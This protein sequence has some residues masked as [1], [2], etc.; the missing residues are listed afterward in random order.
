MSFG[1]CFNTGKNI[2]I[3]QPE[4]I[5]FNTTCVQKGG[6][7][8]SNLGSVVFWILNNRTGQGHDSL[9]IELTCQQKFTHQNKILWWNGPN[10]F[11]FV[12]GIN[13]IDLG[14]HQTRWVWTGNFVQLYSFNIIE[15]WPTRF[16]NANMDFPR[17]KLTET[18]YC[19][20]NFLLFVL[21][22]K[23][24]VSRQ[25]GGG[26]GRDK[27][28]FRGYTWVGD[29]IVRSLLDERPTSTLQKIGFNGFTIRRIQVRHLIYNVI[30]FF[31][32]KN[33]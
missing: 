19:R 22:N 21:Q 8:S 14:T 4:P 1:I 5:L 10:R 18:H 30:L 27:N 24:R 12:N 13:L 28:C 33:L 2:S 25:W 3:D 6:N 26:I 15:R 31:I 9:G 17:C 23:V 29:H 11:T 7:F 16:S 20:L 32:G